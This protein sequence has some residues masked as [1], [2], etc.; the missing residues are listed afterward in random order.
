[1][2]QCEE[3]NTAT[4]VTTLCIPSKGKFSRG[5]T[6]YEK[7]EHR[8]PVYERSWT[9]TIFTGPVSGL[10]NLGNGK[11][12]PDPNKMLLKITLWQLE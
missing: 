3:H 2:A 4:S 8:G 6:A 10:E 12:V 9:P 11:R 1:M 7:N 5:I